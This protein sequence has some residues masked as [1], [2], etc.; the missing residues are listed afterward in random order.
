M[1]KLDEKEVTE[2]DKL[3]E[4]EVTKLDKLDEK[5]VTELGKLDGKKVRDLVGRKKVGDLMERRWEDLTFV[6][7][8]SYKSLAIN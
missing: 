4:K 8:K 6:G 5:E 1:S 3:D 2:L 7:K